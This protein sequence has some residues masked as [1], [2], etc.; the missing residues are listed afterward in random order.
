M[1]IEK[2]SVDIDADSSGFQSALKIVSTTLVD[3]KSLVA[4]INSSITSMA[5]IMQNNLN[6]VAKAA[7]NARVSVSDTADAVSDMANTASGTIHMPNFLPPAVIPNVQD[8]VSPIVKP[9]TQDAQESGTDATPINALEQAANAAQSA[10]DN[11]TESIVNTTQAVTALTNSFSGTAAA[12][13]NATN[14]D[15]GKVEEGAND[16]AD[17]L[18]N[19]KDSAKDAENGLNKTGKQPKKQRMNSGKQNPNVLHS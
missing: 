17:G 14:V 9:S 7:D 13:A 16:A 3:I 11:L 5:T 19:V 10:V 12:V 15:L 6:G 2:L 18:D 4:S 1:A 8:T